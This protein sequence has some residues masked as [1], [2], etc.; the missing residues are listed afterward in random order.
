MK[1][2]VIEHQ[3]L[4][5]WEN[6]LSGYEQKSVVATFGTQLE[7]LECQS[8][9]FGDLL[10]VL[11]FL[12]PESIPLNMII[13]GAEAS[14]FR[15][16]LSSNV[17]P[18]SSKLKPFLL[19]KMAWHQQRG[20]TT[21]LRDG[22]DNTTSPLFI[23]GKPESLIDLMC[24]PVQLQQAIQQLHSWSLVRYESNRDESVLHIHDLIQLMIQESTRSEDVDHHWFHSAVELVCN[25]FRQ[26]DNPQGTHVGLNV[27]YS[28]HIF[29]H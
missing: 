18:T 2:T 1:L 6:N 10:K 19:H 9:D 17:T 20:E 4:I 7:E 22:T 8:P 14:Q 24:S 29:N 21:T 23:T 25:G 15:S 16:A 3:K 28:P 5:R 13:K 27:R 26:I 12:D 11:S